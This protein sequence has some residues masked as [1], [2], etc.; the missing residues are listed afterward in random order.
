M[1]GLLL[2]SFLARL[3][4]WWEPD[5]VDCNSLQADSMYATREDEMN[6]LANT[7]AY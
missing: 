2:I 1:M 3:A 5:A 6:V 7:V 4:A